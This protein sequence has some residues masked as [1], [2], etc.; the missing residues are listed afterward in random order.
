MLIA[1]N[2]TAIQEILILLDP[3]FDVSKTCHNC[4]VS[5]GRLQSIN[6]VQ[7]HEDNYGLIFHMYDIEYDGHRILKCKNVNQAHFASDGSDN[8]VNGCIT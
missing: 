8:L 1:G 2:Q 4:Y 3:M 7:Y 5:F 6:D